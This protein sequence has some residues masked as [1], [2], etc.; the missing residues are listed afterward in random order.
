M[1]V[2]FPLIAVVSVVVLLYES[3]EI[4]LFNVS[5]DAKIKRGLWN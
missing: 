2:A 1:A 4:W 3:V 5:F